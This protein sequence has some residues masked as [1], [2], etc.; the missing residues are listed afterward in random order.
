MYLVGLFL[1]TKGSFNPATRA[2]PPAYWMDY[3]S[4]GVRTACFS[5][6]RAN[7]SYFA[8]QQERHRS[9]WHTLHQLTEST[10]DSSYIP[11]K[12]HLPV[13]L[14]Q[15]ILCA[16]FHIFFPLY[17]SPSNLPG[18]RGG[19]GNSKSWQCWI[20]KPLLLNMAI[21]KLRITDTMTMCQ[22]DQRW[23]QG[24]R[25][26]EQDHQQGKRAKRVKTGLRRSTPVVCLQTG[27]DEWPAKWK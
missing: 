10:L 27:R 5:L 16:S 24:H 3:H 23:P 6:L 26:L 2:N 19:Q 18:K 1:L 11:N 21:W 22:L 4:K 14:H 12:Q 7:V 15:S 8:V 13:K 20:S 17:S 25:I 9:V